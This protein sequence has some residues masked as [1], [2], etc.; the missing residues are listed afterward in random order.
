V[1]SRVAQFAT[2]QWS[3]SKSFDGACPLGPALVHK[4]AIADLK[5]VSITGS[6]S[7][8]VVQKSTME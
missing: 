8:K 3:Y 5:Q 1:S 2:S 4:D 6:L 7:G